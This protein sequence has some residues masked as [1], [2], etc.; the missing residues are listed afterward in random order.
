MLRHLVLCH[1]VVIDPNNGEYNAS[2]PDELALIQGAKELGARFLSKDDHGLCK[3]SLP[4]GSEESYEVLS[5][6]EFSS[7][8]KR[9]SIVIRDVSSRKYFL[10][11]KGADSMVFPMLIQTSSKVQSYVDEFAREGLRTLVLA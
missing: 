1:T 6:Q 8:R 10:L 2:S 5:V 7:A 4:G 3:I 11:I 9:M